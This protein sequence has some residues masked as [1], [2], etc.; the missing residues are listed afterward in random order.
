MASFSQ[1]TNQPAAAARLQPSSVPSLGCPGAHSSTVSGPKSIDKIG[2][3]VVHSSAHTLVHADAWAGQ[4][5]GWAETKSQQAIKGA[6]TG[7]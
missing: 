5:G 2:M 1:E 6:Q 4:K 7:W 3:T